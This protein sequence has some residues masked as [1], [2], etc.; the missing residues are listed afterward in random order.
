MGSSFTVWHS[1]SMQIQFRMKLNTSFKISKVFLNHSSEHF[2]QSISHYPLLLCKHWQDCPWTLSFA[3]F[4]LHKS[5]RSPAKNKRWTIC[6]LNAMNIW[7][8]SETILLGSFPPR[9]SCNQTIFSFTATI[10]KVELWDKNRYWTQAFL[11]HKIMIMLNTQ[12][13]T[14]IR[15]HANV[16]PK[17]DLMQFGS[18][19]E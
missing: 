11:F 14:W 12:C 8:L 17:S 4:C 5:N 3:K 15:C 9:N 16:A 13:T 18:A 2:L 7:A 10:V 1:K 19:H 6:L